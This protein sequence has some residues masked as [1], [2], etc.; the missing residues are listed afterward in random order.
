MQC[1]LV[2]NRL[3]TVCQRTCGVGGNPDGPKQVRL[4]QWPQAPLDHGS[5]GQPYLVL[6]H[7][8]TGNAHSFDQIAAH[9]RAKHHVIALDFRGHGDSDWGPPDGYTPQNYLGDLSA[10]MKALGIETASFIGSS[11][12]GAMAMIFAAIAPH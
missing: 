9:L 11:L 12:G 1:P 2:V 10:V 5:E 7:G 3:C 4:R 8:L 6:L